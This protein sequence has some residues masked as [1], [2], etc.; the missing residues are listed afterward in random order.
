MSLLFPLFVLVA[1]AAAITS[2]APVVG[3]VAAV[4]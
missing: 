4:G 3:A 2:A 1:V